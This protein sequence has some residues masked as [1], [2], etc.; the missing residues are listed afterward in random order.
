MFNLFASFIITGLSALLIKR[1]AL[2]KTLSFVVFAVLGYAFYIFMEMG[3]DDKV[4][5][6]TYSWL[7]NL[8][9]NLSFNLFNYQLLVPIFIISIACAF[10][11]FLQSLPKSMGLIILNLAAIILLVCASNLV[12]IFLSL[13]FVEI[14]GLYLLD[15][16][17]N[18]N[19]YVYYNLVADFLIFFVFAT[20]YSVNGRV[21]IN[22]LSL[23]AHKSLLSTVF[24]VAILMKMGAFIFYEYL[25]S[26]KDLKIFE[27]ITFLYTSTPISALIIFYKLGFFLNSDYVTA[28]AILTSLLGLFSFL[29]QKSLKQKIIFL[30]ISSYALILMCFNNFEYLTPILLSSFIISYIL[31]LITISASDE[32]NISFMGQFIK[33]TKTLFAAFLVSII[34][35]IMALMQLPQN[36]FLIVYLVL[37]LVFVAHIV[38]IVFFAKNNVEERVWDNLKNPQIGFY[39]PLLLLWP[40]L[41]T[42]YQNINIWYFGAV[43]VLSLIFYP[44]KCLNNIAYSIKDNVFSAIFEYMLIIPIK[45]MGRVLWLTI[46]FLII[47]KTFINYIS[48]TNHF[49]ITKFEIVENKNIIWIVI[50]FIFMALALGISYL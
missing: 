32:Y 28:I 49:L 48:K 25:Y 35:V 29:L 39:I 1:E 45:I 6:N 21:D 33:K 42:P 9:L 8:K 23:G 50:G 22:N 37:L 12:Q 11:A 20:I 10:V 2:K 34:F 41:Y 40:S 15:N 26:I 43:F 47:E 3:I 36:L 13:F 46:D 17:K 30:A 38:K 14:I 44:I 31:M 5:P 7:E 24:F 27:I 16:K 19:K 18:K 4:I